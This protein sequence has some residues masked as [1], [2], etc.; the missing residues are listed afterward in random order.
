MERRCVMNILNWREHAD[1]F[2]DDPMLVMAVI[3]TGVS[4]VFVF[5]FISRLMNAG[6]RRRPH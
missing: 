2:F 4:G 3:V 6:D 1:N 5:T